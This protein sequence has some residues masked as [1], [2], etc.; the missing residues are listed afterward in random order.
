MKSGR[1]SGRTQE[2][3]DDLKRQL[4]DD[5][6]KRLNVR[7]TKGEYRRLKQFALDKDRSVSD[8]TRD[9]LRE[10]MSK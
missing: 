4:D 2:R 6:E 1:P 9:A 3:I 8:V 5:E 7:M 10:Y